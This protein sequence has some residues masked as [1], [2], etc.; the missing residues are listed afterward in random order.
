M[1]AQRVLNVWNRL[2]VMI[3]PVIYFKHFSS[4]IFMPQLY[5]VLCNSDYFIYLYNVVSLHRTLPIHT[6]YIIVDK[7]FNTFADMT[8][9]DV[10]FIH[11]SNQ[12][13]FSFFY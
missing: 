1:E 2:Y 7:C 12:F 6:V 13:L 8:F 4:V 3:V 11:T 5:K 10:V 9:A